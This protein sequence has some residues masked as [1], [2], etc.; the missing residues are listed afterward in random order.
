MSAKCAMLKK[1]VIF[2]LDGVLLDSM[3][4]YY[5]AWGAAFATQDIILN[6]NQFYEREGEQRIKSVREIFEN[7]KGYRPST[8]VS[9]DILNAMHNTFL[10]SFQLK[11]FP[12]TR[13][14]L[15][16]LVGKRI[17]L[18]LVTGSESLEQM[19]G[20][21]RDLLSLFSAIVTG[22]ETR[23][24]KPAPEPYELAIQRLG[25]PRSSCCA[26]ENAPFGIR[27]AK[28]AGLF[29][30]AV[31]NTSPLPA[32]KL[33]QAGADVVCSSNKDLLKQLM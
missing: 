22:R 4:Y 16:A 19:F 13:E 14:L 17:A 11:L 31:R 33:K 5:E 25:L 2:D 6:K 3:P 20:P 12:C 30:F 8:R 18:G 23:E 15:T 24:G 7:N 9:E 27:S 26:V 28:A 29:C 32:E 10:E 1:A 21:E